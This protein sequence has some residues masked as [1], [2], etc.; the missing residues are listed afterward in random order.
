M[1]II[2]LLLV[3]D[4][5][6]PFQSLWDFYSDN[7]VSS[8]ACGRGY[9]GIASTGDISSVFIN[10]ASLSLENKRQYYFEYTYKNNVEWD[11]NR[12]FQ[13][14]H[15]NFSAG[16]AF[17]IN[18]FLQIG[19]T[20]RTEKSFSEGTE[21][22]HN[23]RRFIYISNGDSIPF[24]DYIADNIPYGFPYPEWLPDS[25]D[26]L[27]L[28]TSYVDTIHR[29]TDLKIS[30]FSIPIVINFKNIIRIG[31]DI[32]YTTFYSKIRHGESGENVPGIPIKFNKIIPKFGFI[33]SPMENLSFGLTYT[34]KITE[35]IT[36]NPNSYY[37]YTQD[38][39][40]FPTKIG[41]G[42]NYKLN[43]FPLSLSLDYIRSHNS[44]EENLINRNDIHLGLEYDISNNFKIKTGFFTQ[45][46]YRDSESQEYY[47]ENFGV[48]NYNQIFTTFGLSYK[49]SSLALNLSLMDSHLFSNGHIE[50]TYVNTGISYG[51]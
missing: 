2:V 5:Y 13:E 31:V 10:P 25:L 14:L 8:S 34:P 28:D 37:S 39:N 45:R 23:I 41:I 42:I 51:F 48:G 44:M 19:T 43:L 32:N 11:T 12:V 18:D 21:Y 26:S 33:Y 1:N 22:I 47:Q 24:Y 49:I 9:S 3:A 29:N 20:Y 35:S 46:D 40:I 30:S 38:P 15:P 50:Q 6:I 7:R 4:S 27:S 16:H 17:S 36:V